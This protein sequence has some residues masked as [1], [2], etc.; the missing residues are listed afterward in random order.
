MSRERFMQL[1]QELITMTD[2]DNAQDV[3]DAKEILK[4]LLRL[5]QSSEKADAYTIRSISG[6]CTVFE[7]LLRNKDHFAGIPGDDDG[8]RIKRKRL[9]NAIYPYC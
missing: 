3:E 1:L 6:S 8:N 4:R 5:A 9:W 2:P 7:M